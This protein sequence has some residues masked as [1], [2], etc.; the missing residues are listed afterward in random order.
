MSVR[1]DLNSSRWIKS[2]FNTTERKLIRKQ[3]R[4]IELLDYDICISFL[5]NDSR[6]L[7]FVRGVSSKDN[8]SC[9]DM[10]PSTL[11]LNKRQYNSIKELIDKKDKVENHYH[12]SLPLLLENIKSEV[13][14]PIF[15]YDNI[16]NLSMKLIGCLYLGS[17]IYKEFPSGFFS[18]DKE[19]NEKVSDISKLLTLCLARFE[20]ISDAINMIDIFIDILEQKD[21]YLSNHSYNVA[22]WCREIGMELGFSREELNQLAF[23]GLLHDLGKCMIDSKV[24]NKPETLTEEEYAIIKYHILYSYKISKNLL[25]HIEGLDDIPRIIKYHHERYDGKGY[26]S[27]LKGDEVPFESYIIGISDS[28]DAML[29][30]KPYKKAMPINAVIRELYRE[31]GKQFHP[32]LV[33]I[34]VDRLTKAQNQLKETHYH[35]VGLSFLIISYEKKVIIIEGAL[36]NMGNYYIFN[37]DEESKVDGI[38][39]SK[40]ANVEMVVKKLNNLNYYE[41]KLEDLIDNTFY[42]SSIKLIPSPNTFNLLWNLEGILYWGDGNRK[43]PIEIIRIGGDALSFSLHD[44][45][46]IGIPIGKPLKVKILFEEYDIDITGSILK[47]YDFGP[48][49]Y[50]DLH[51]TNIPDSKRDAIYR[52]LFRKQIELRKTISEYR[53]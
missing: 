2:Q 48:Y 4:I 41:I 27:G 1:I 15:K 28:V 13:L 20:Q 35:T 33:D 38:D 22:N 6:N 32:Q 45:W 30:N 5:F 7:A 37:P 36:F 46:A 42:I 43:T 10:I 3:N 49:K 14:I 51:Y 50:F 24:L 47:S 17:N 8:H 53:I 52:Q 31:K 18:E 19:I 39:L 16:D 26:P 12:S 34:M 11:F 21:P 44:N 40:I 23:A 25:G 29:T 9:Q